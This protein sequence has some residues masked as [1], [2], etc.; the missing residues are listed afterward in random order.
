MEIHLPSPPTPPTFPGNLFFMPQTPSSSAPSSLYIDDLISLRKQ[1]QPEET[2]HALTHHITPCTSISLRLPNFLCS[3]Q[4]LSQGTCS[5]PFSSIQGQGYISRN[6]HSSLSL[7]NHSLQPT[8][9]ILFS[10]S[11]I[12]NLV[13]LTFSSSY[14]P[15]PLLSFA[16]ITLK[17]AIYTCSD[18]SNSLTFILSL[19]QSLKAFITTNS[20]T[21]ALACQ[22]HQWPSFVLNQIINPQFYLTWSVSSIGHN[23]HH[24]FQEH[25]T[26]LACPASLSYSV[27]PL[28]CLNGPPKTTQNCPTSGFPHSSKKQCHRPLTQINNLEVLFDSSHFL[29]FSYSTSNQTENLLALSSTQ[30]RCWSHSSTVTAATLV[31]ATIHLKGINQRTT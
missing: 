22:G 1:S 19:T 13:C 3:Y 14:Y 27:L 11:Y 28:S 9:M 23:N 12:D 31:Q 6:S 16:V 10:A 17:G 7:T 26:Q 18:I 2:F 15:F 30:Y 20:I 29:M 5:H 4:P 8:A 25:F 24:L 21:I